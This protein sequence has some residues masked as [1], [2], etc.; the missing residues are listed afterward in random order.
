MN[1][2][3]I[4]KSNPVGVGWGG[5]NLFR[6][7]GPIICARAHARAASYGPQGCNG[8]TRPLRTLH[9]TLTPLL[10]VTNRYDRYKPLQERVYA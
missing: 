7:F 5:R 2:I 10:S 3:L 1:R 4:G 8:P 6:F 9:F